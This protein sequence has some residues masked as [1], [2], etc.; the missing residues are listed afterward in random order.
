[1]YESACARAVHDC[2]ELA[3]LYE[4]GKAIKKNA[5]R[6]KELRAKIAKSYAEDCE[7]GE[8]H[9][10]SLL[11]DL[12]AT[13][14]GVPKDAKKAKALAAQACALGLTMSCDD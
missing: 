11:A 3:E 8:A 10:C 9:A 13:G 6:A 14:L 2:D 1:L 4:Q 7:R 5:K 12:H